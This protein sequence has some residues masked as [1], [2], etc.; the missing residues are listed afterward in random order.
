MPGWAEKALAKLDSKERIA[1]GHT[2]RYLEERSQIKA[3]A[4]HLWGQ[5]VE[6]LQ[7]E[8]DNFNRARPDYLALTVEPSKGTVVGR[9]AQPPTIAFTLVFDCDVPQIDY[10]IDV[11]GPTHTTNTG[12]GVFAFRVQ[13]DGAV[14]FMHYS[15]G[16]QYNVPKAAEYFLDY[17]VQ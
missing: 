15:T 2:Q 12:K 10:R 11:S 9:C 16:A 13:P 6:V 7:A 17:L 14:W 8:V 1:E 3:E 5:L 4:P